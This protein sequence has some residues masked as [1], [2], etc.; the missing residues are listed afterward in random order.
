MILPLSNPDTNGSEHRNRG[1]PGGILVYYFKSIVNG[2]N[3][4]SLKACLYAVYD[5]IELGKASCPTTNDYKPRACHNSAA[6]V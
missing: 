6:A 4:G 5:V 1:M 2:L 3:I